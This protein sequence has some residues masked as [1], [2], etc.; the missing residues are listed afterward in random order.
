MKSGDSVLGELGERDDPSKLSDRG[1]AVLE[2]NIVTVIWVGLRL[3]DLSTAGDAG[4]RLAH[5]SSKTD[6]S[7]LALSQ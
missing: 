3:T 1:Q 7:L 2:I 4:L 5:L 6:F